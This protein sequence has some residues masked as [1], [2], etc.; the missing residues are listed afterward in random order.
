MAVR[1][2]FTDAIGEEIDA[3]LAPDEDR[4]LRVY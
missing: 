1:L 4:S 3:R 2:L